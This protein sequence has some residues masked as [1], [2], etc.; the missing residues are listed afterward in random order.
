M[1]MGNVFDK[2]G[3]VHKCNSY[4]KNLF[5]ESHYRIVKRLLTQSFL[6]RTSV[7]KPFRKIAKS[8]YWLCHVCPSVRT[9]NSAPTGRIF[10]KFGTLIF[11]AD[12]WGKFKFHQNMMRITGT[13]PEDQ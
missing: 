4:N 11:F 5:A 9:D 2:L 8:D 6:Q 10:I 13:L 7:N 1:A 12:L 3:N